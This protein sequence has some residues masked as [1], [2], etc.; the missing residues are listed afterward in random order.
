MV[1]RMKKRNRDVENRNQEREREQRA[2]VVLKET[3]N[4]KHIKYDY[5]EIVVVCFIVLVLIC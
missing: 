5:I 2:D 4:M 1:F 3:S